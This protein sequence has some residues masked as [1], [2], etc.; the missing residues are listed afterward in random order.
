MFWVF[1]PP[2]LE[3]WFRAIGKPRKAGDPEPEPFPRP[4]NTDE[5]MAFQ[6]FVK[7]KS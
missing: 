7:P 1:M 4:P 3:E 5:A 6:K 2:K